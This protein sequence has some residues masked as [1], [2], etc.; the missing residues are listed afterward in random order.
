[1][2]QGAKI[3]IIGAGIGGLSAALRLA[4]RGCDVTLLETAS[5][6]GGKIRTLPTDQGPADTGPTVLT[7]R[8]VFEA[9]FA[10]VGATL[11]DH[12]TLTPLPVL[13]RHFWPG[14]QSLDLMADQDVSAR[15]I[16]DTFGPRA[17]A[18]FQRYSA[19]TRAL[20]D[21]FDAPMMQTAAPSLS[22]MVA[23]VASNPRIIPKMAPHQSLAKM[24]R[25]QFSDPELAQLFGRYA[26]YVGGMPA[27]VPA[28]LSL[29]SQAEAD[30]VWAVEGGMTALPRAIA[31]LA[32]TKGALFHYDTQVK[33]IE[34]QGGRAALVHTANARFEADAVLF[35]GD[36][37][38]LEAGL[39]GHGARSAVQ[40]TATNPRSLSACVLAFS[41]IMHGP[42]LSHHNVFFGNDLHAEFNAIHQGRLP[43]DPTLYLCAQ[44]HG[45][46]G[47]PP[48]APGRYEI[49]MN[50]PAGL[51]LSLEEQEKCLKRIFDRLASFGLTC[52]PRPGLRALTVP[53][54]WDRLFPASQGALYG[55]SPSGMMAAF[56]RPTARSRLKGLYLV[57]GGAH[58]GAGVP[59]ATLSGRHAAEAI[60][61]DLTSASMSGQ[62]AMP[63]GMSTA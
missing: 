21:A 37:R 55:R 41:G 29:I 60:W 8:H 20:F 26:T 7:M 33:R 10:D 9:L 45:A 61:T 58:P 47:Q 62:T 39:L 6:P 27:R 18:E 48:G 22:A 40:P 32:A 1:M 15:N 28:L 52:D 30:G 53:Q 44:D 54:D 17:E 16:R 14:G 19:R 31:D 49:I 3:I 38:A 23:K 46:T 42:E 59:M 35:N 57:G 63:G 11:S 36:P 50:A 56:Q 24:L 34:S 4:H 5:A 12:V 13:A 43:D 25:A 2:G 51:I